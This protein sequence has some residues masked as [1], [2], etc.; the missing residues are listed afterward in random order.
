MFAIYKDKEN[1][2]TKVMIGN[3]KYMNENQVKAK[4]FAKSLKEEQDD[5]DYDD[6]N[7]YQK[8]KFSVG[9]AATSDDSTVE[10]EEIE[11]DDMKYEDKYLAVVRKKANELEQN[12]NTCVFVAVNNSLCA[13][14][15]IADKIKADAYHVIDYL[16]NKQNTMLYDYW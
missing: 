9:S 4:K 6:G 11:H 12:G 14:L 8:N 7:N 15:A 1:N 5:D 3:I 2:Q 16:Q 10:L 13:I